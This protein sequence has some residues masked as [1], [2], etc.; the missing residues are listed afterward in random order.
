MPTAL[1]A[2]RPDGRTTDHSAEIHA[3]RRHLDIGG[4]GLQTHVARRYRAAIELLEQH[5]ATLVSLDTMPSCADL[6]N[7]ALDNL[8]YGPFLPNGA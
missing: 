5:D 1:D 3:L 4:F 8:G 7:Q 2:G 6:V